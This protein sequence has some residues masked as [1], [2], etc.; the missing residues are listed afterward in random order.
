LASARPLAIDQYAVEAAPPSA[1]PLRSSY[2]TSG[3]SA[4]ATLLIELLNPKSRWYT[5]LLTTGSRS[6]TGRFYRQTN[7]PVEASEIFA[8]DFPEAVKIA[9]SYVAKA[10]KEST[11]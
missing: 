2:V 1:I 7:V 10:L 6:N 4:G 11:P 9:K 3:H 5:L 8:I